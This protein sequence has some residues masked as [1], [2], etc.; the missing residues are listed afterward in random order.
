MAV[1]PADLPAAV[2]ERYRPRPDRRLLLAVA[3]IQRLRG[4]AAPAPVQAEFRD[5]RWRI[6][7]GG[8]EVSVLSS[9]RRSR[10]ATGLLADGL[11]TGR[12]S[13]AAVP[14]GAT[15]TSG[16]ERA[17]RD[18]DAASLLKALSSL[19]G[20]PADALRDEAKVRSIASG[21]AWSATMTVDNLDQADPLL[22]EAWPWLALER[23][24]DAGGEALVARALGY[25]AAAARAGS[26]LSADDPVRLYAAG[27]EVRLGALCAGRPADRP[28]HFLHLALLA[29][30]EQRE[31]FHTA[32]L[33][34]PFKDETS[35][36]ALGC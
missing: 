6:L 14:A 3:E 4:G 23:S 24:R 20:S 30:R 8:D 1:A 13:P 5:G 17:V 19:G 7:V 18:L 15:D 25:E 2:R 29:E 21:L 9:F 36:A 10:E 22:A 31:R 35:L 16:L 33:A 28:C 32:F 27:D 11:L 12:P 34:S 26:K